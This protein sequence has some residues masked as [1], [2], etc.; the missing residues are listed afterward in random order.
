MLAYAL[1]NLSVDL[2]PGRGQ[3]LLAGAKFG[4][5]TRDLG[6]FLG[7]LRLELQARGLDQRSGER[8]VQLDLFVAM[9]AF[10]DGSIIVPPFLKPIQNRILRAGL[11]FRLWCINRLPA[12][13]FVGRPRPIDRKG[14]IEVVYSFQCEFPP[15]S[16]PSIRSKAAPRFAASACMCGRTCA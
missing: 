5:A 10:D 7:E 13:K 6:V 14:Q 16:Q 3:Q 8:F 12:R 15:C 1:L 9:R 2:L 4:F 11:T